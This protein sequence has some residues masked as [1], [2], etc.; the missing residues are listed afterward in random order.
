MSAK[1]DN[2]WAELSAIRE[3]LD[4]GTCS[5][6]RSRFLS[7]RYAELTSLLDEAGWPE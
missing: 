6:A 2:A 4:R 7:Q 1:T 3:E 5:A